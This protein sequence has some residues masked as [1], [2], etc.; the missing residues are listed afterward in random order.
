MSAM[1]KMADEGRTIV[2][3][4]HQ[5]SSTI[6]DMFDDL[7]LLKKGG[8]VVFHGSL[9]GSSSNLITY[10]ENLGC[11]P[12]SRG[13]NPASW[14]LD[15]LGASV[16]GQEMD[17]AQA[18]KESSN[19]EAIQQELAEVSESKDE[20]LKIKYAKQ[21][22]VPWRERDRLMAERLVKIYWRSPM[23]NLSRLALCTV[24]G[25]G[26]GLVFLPERSHELLKEA[27]MTRYVMIH[28]VPL[29]SNDN[30]HYSCRFFSV[31]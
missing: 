17:F 5:P 7:L 19:Y 26:I 16:D 27:Y 9:G 15:V 14:M 25:L 2:A 12:I 21:F 28:G 1:R 13:A 8:H 10:F 22:A 24:I 30:S 29:I 4:I 3:T 11:N 31:F 20:A 23:F 18:W 6:F